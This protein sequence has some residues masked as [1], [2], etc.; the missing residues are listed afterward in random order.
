MRTAALFGAVLVL[1]QLKAAQNL[2][3]IRFIGNEAFEISDGSTTILTDYPYQ[4][5]Y[6]GYM[7]YDSATVRPAGRVL[8]LITHRHPDHFDPTRFTD[9]SWRIMA[10]LEVTRAVRS[11]QV[12]RLDSVVTFGP[13][14]I[15][16]IRTPHAGTEHYAY[17]IEWGPL[18]LFFPGDTEDPASLLGQTGLTHAFLT[19]WLWNTLRHQPDRVP[20]QHIV[21]YHHEE[22]ERIISCP[23]C[24][25][26]HQ[27]ERR[28]ALVP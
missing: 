1:S 12:V 28:P 2:P 20:A 22:G 5:G 15:R 9:R 21:F 17:L 13:A 14:T 27:G 18:K 16:P 8:A 23:K 6:S 10:P 3:S 25:Q 11:A 7:R 26:P 24:W 19:P 4:P